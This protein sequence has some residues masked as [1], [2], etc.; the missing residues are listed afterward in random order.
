MRRVMEWV[1][2]GWGKWFRWDWM[3]R[4]LGKLKN[5]GGSRNRD[6]EKSGQTLAFPLLRGDGRPCIIGIHSSVCLVIFCLED[7]R[8]SN[9]SVGVVQ[10]ADVPTGF[11]SLSDYAQVE[12]KGLILVHTNPDNLN[13]VDLYERELGRDVMDALRA[14]VQQLRNVRVAHINATSYGGGVAEL[15]HRQIPLMNQLGES[16]GFQSDWLILN[17]EN[18]AFY[19]V[20]KKCHNTLQGDPGS[21]SPAEKEQYYRTLLANAHHG[22]LNGYDVVIIH[23]PQPAALIELYPNRTNKWAWRCHIDTTTPNPQVWDFIGQFAKQHDVAIWT[24]DSFVTDR[25]DFKEIRI[26]PPS[27]DPI[28]PKN[29]SLSD[30]EIAEVFARFGVDQSR[31]VLLQVSRFDPWKQP[32]EVIQVYKELKPEFPTLQLVLA[33]SMATDDPEGMQYWEQS[34]RKAGEDPDIFILNNYHGVGNKEIN[35]FQRGASVVLQYSSKEG[36][37]LTVSEG[38]WK[39]QPMIGGKVGGIQDQIVHGESGYLVSTNDEV[40]AAIRELL[41]NPDKR[42]QMGEKAQQRV[43]EHFLI[44]REV[45][46]YLTLI[47]DLHASA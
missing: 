7:T 42:K 34:L 3:D 40:K 44:T 45:S 43:A 22:Q 26:I 27:I 47:R 17:V 8:V 11:Q 16:V 29:S 15:L 36:F 41:A 10:A 31:P 18:P 25:A 39:R 37:G 9:D 30:E 19:D 24:R 35:A 5:A 14:L 23:D 28:S 46:D 12:D 2:A 13:L 1:K 6:L 38:M 32:L 33:G 21:L 4:E 20:T